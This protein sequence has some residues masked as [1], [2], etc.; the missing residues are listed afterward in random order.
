M[1]ERPVFDPA[2][3]FWDIPGESAE[4]CLRFLGTELIKAGKAKEDYIDALLEREANYPTGL[5]TP[6][7]TIAIPHANPENALV[8]TFAVAKPAHPV[9][10][11]HMADEEQEVEAEL[12]LMMCIA[13]PQDQAPMLSHIMEMF[14]DSTLEKDFRA[15]GSAEELHEM[16]QRKA[17]EKVER[18]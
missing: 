4:D 14:S 16:L 10:F 18:G 1:N 9:V 2:L 8:N 11:H 15:C 17:D 7:I 12:I 13:D 6:S 5:M 3:V